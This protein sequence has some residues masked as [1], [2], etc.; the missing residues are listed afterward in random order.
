MVKMNGALCAPPLTGPLLSIFNRAS[1]QITS[2]GGTV[3]ECPRP[4]AAAEMGRVFRGVL[5][6]KDCF[7]S[8]P[9]IL[10]RSQENGGPPNS[11]EPPPVLGICL[12]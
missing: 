11:G 3:W 7:S 8:A 1:D 12:P 4:M 6:L 2:H 10:F 9:V 5:S